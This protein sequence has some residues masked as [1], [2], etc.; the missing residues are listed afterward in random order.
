[1]S[2]INCVLGIAQMSR[3]EEILAARRRVAGQYE[4][5]LSDLPGVVL[6]VEPPDSRRSWFVYVVR[7][8]RCESRQDL[9]EVIRR[10]RDR[11]IG[12][13]NYFYPIHLQPFY[14]TMFGYAEGDFPVT[15]RVSAQ[16]LALPFHNRLS[17][18]DAERVVDALRTTLAEL[19][20]GT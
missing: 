4:E 3:I 14:R 8:D 2:D 6:P 7:L 15:E 13:S 9:D 5:L 1:L 20:L 16:T 19:G 12:C 11:G 18:R 17:R 10:L